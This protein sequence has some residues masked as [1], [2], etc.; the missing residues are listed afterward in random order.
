MTEKDIRLIRRRFREN[1]SNI[2]SIRGCFVNESKNIIAHIDQSLFG[3][4]SIVVNQLLSVMKKCLSGSLGTNLNEIPFSTKDVTDGEE[5]KL[6][7][8]LRNSHLSDTESLSALYQKIIDSVEMESGYVILLASDVYDIIKK[9][10]D[11]TEAETSTSFTYFVC[12]VCPIKATLD[13]LYFK[14]SERLFH[15]LNASSL[16]TKPQIGFMFPAFENYGANI[17]SA[18]Y[19]TKSISDNNPKLIENVFRHTPPMPPSEQKTTFDE[20]LASS[21]GDECSLD[22]VRSV[23]NQVAEIVESHKN[24]KEEDPLTLSKSDMKTILEGC[25]VAEEKIEDFCEKLDES[26]GK[27][28]LLTPTNIINCKKF[29]LQTPHVSITV[30]PDSRDLVTTEVINGVEYILIKATDGVE[31]NGINVKF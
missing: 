18:L 12:A 17:Y 24:T 11:G 6:L 10:K 20:L 27:N 29:K 16:L 28:A 23:H 3:A 1:G 5:H 7:M 19:Y 30:D 22:V 15:N 13:G 21:L 4:D 14:E 26:F 25:G 8:S 31:V 9:S 2:S